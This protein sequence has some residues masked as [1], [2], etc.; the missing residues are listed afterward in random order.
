MQTTAV[1]RAQNQLVLQNFA[2]L[3]KKKKNLFCEVGTRAGL[4][5]HFN[6]DSCVTESDE[7][8]T[9]ADVKTVRAQQYSL[10]FILLTTI[11]KN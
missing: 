2:K 7:S 3:Q 6:P 9:A 4:K 1:A 5:A 8:V 10:S 11:N